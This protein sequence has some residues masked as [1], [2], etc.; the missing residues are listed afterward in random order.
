[1]AYHVSS[2]ELDLKQIRKFLTDFKKT[3][4]HISLGTHR[5][6]TASPDWVSIVEQDL[7]FKDMTV[8][9]DADIFIKMTEA[10]LDLDTNEIIHQFSLQA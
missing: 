9:E 1:M 3:H 10:D 7:F 5:L 4:T 8:T 6:S 2:K